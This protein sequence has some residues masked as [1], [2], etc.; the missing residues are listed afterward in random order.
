MLSS[1]LERLCLERGIR[2]TGQRRVIASVL[3]DAADHP[4]AEELY[5]RAWRI[6]DQISLATVYRTL[7]LFEEWGVLARHDRGDGRARYGSRPDGRRPGLGHAA[8]P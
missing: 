2:L 4:D 6:D 7:R 3:A 5:R 8:A 1:A